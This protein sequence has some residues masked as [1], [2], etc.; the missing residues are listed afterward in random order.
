[1]QTS[2]LAPQGD[3]SKATGENLLW[4]DSLL[5]WMAAAVVAVAIFVAGAA[6]I[7]NAVSTLQEPRQMSVQEPSSM[8]PKPSQCRPVQALGCPPATS[9]GS[10]AGLDFFLFGTLLI[11][12]LA[13]PSDLPDHASATTR[14]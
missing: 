12:I 9:I 11:R 5:F 10:G 14:R 7:S 3:T 13:T 4:S 8:P 2:L 6:Q 1:M